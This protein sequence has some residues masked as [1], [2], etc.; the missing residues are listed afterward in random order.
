MN[1]GSRAFI[2]FTPGGG[3]IR[4]LF[5]P[6]GRLENGDYNGKCFYWLLGGLFGF[7]DVVVKWGNVLFFAFHAGCFIWVFFWRCVEKCERGPAGHGVDGIL[8]F[9]FIRGYF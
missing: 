1:A 6:G 7:S 5:L 3:L 8:L 2:F 9:M 4:A